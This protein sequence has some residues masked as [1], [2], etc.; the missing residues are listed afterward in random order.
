MFC[1]KCGKELNNGALVCPDCG[2]HISI[3]SVIDIFRNA[4][5]IWNGE[6]TNNDCFAYNIPEN[7]KS[8][9]RQNFEI[10]YNE[11]I[12]FVRDTSFWDSRDQ[13]VLF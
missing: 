4:R 13:K 11:Q 6:V 1:K 5:G 3:R 9:I 12:L 10:S 2:Y 7:V 8:L